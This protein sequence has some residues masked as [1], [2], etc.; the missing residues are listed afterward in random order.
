M[1][2]KLL[3]VAVENVR[4]RRSE[5]DCPVTP[6]YSVEWLEDMVVALSKQGE[7][8]PMRGRWR[9]FHAL[10]MDKCWGIES[11]DSELI[12]SGDEVIVYPDPG[13]SEKAA[14]L[15][16]DAHNAAI[17]VAEGEQISDAMVE[18][19]LNRW[20]ERPFKMIGHTDFEAMRDTL[21]DALSH[22]FTSS[23]Q[24]S[25]E[26]EGEPKGH[27]QDGG[28]V[29]VEDHDCPSREAV[30][31]AY[32]DALKNLMGIYDTPLSRRRFPQDDFMKEALDTAR[33]LLKEGE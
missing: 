17:A 9:A 12:E 23:E 28:K 25:G 15:V 11:E 4:K 8:P 6:A 10:G 5:G 13:I 1:H 3:E 14:R 29:W 19:A 30:I 7:Q 18:A 22:L 2:K 27:W 20:D 31:R 21:K 32:K 16:V 26:A 33:A 24:I